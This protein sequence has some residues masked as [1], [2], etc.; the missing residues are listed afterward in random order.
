MKAILLTLLTLVSLSFNLQA[1]HRFIDNFKGRGLTIM[2]NYGNNSI[3]IASAT[4]FFSNSAHNKQLNIDLEALA[5]VI[6]SAAQNRYGEGVGIGVVYVPSVIPFGATPEGRYGWSNI[7]AYRQSADGITM[8]RSPIYLDQ[9]KINGET[10]KKPAS[11]TWTLVFDLN[12]DEDD[13]WID[14]ITIQEI[15]VHS[16][17]HPDINFTSKIFI[18]ANDFDT[19]MLQTIVLPVG[20]HDIE[21]IEE[22]RFTL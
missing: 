11:C 12:I 13:V 17:N 4:N 9:F 19:E 6:S 14:N 5:N 8:I 3:S 2:H 1:A 21:R 22:K 10:L 18:P 7:G 16:C 15:W 20:T